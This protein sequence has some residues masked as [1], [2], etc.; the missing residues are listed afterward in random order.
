MSITYLPV[1]VDLLDSSRKDRKVKTARITSTSLPPQVKSGHDTTIIRGKSRK[2]TFVTKPVAS[3][4]YT[5][6]DCPSTLNPQSKDF[7]QIYFNL[8][9]KKK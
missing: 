4:T 9:M 8:K 3:P 7:L 1:V 2:Q 5:K 6:K